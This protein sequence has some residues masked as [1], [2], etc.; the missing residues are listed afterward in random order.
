MPMEKS[1]LL[2][3]G[4]KMWELYQLIINAVLERGGSDEDV[5]RFRKDRRLIGKFADLIVSSTKP[6]IVP[7]II[8]DPA[9]PFVR[10]M[11]RESGWKL[12]KEIVYEPGAVKLDF[13]ELLYPGEQ[14][15]NGTEMA[16]RADELCAVL[17]QKHAEAFMTQYECWAPPVGVL[18]ATFP[19]TVWEG[20]SGYLYVPC[21][22]WDGR[23]WHLSFR[24]LDR[25]WHSNDR[26]S[27]SRK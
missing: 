3:G 18:Y 24:W 7:T 4:G 19:G 10:E 1:A 15:V 26:L 21:L 16:R 2:S 6:T 5:E 22:G 17:G 27:R 14:A 13:I 11:A 20:K 23:R 25:Q 12:K 8:I 9:K